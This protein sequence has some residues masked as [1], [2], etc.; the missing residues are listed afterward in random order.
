MGVKFDF[1]LFFSS[2]TRNVNHGLVT[3]LSFF[4]LPAC[5]WKWPWY[6]IG[7]NKYRLKADGKPEKA[8]AIGPSSRREREPKK[9][10]AYRSSP[11]VY[12]HYNSP[13]ERFTQYVV[14]RTLLFTTKSSER[15]AK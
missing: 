9:G 12:A 5:N 3:A 8:K 10:Y 4:S 2:I 13:T 7:I 14:Q 6:H 1:F 15:R 11:H